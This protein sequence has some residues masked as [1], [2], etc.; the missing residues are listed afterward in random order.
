LCRD[1]RAR[2]ANYGDFRYLYVRSALDAAYNVNGRWIGNVVG[3]DNILC[4]NRSINA[5]NHSDIGNFEGTCN[6]FDQ[7]SYWCAY[8]R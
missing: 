7:R 8:D 4:G 1:L 5:D 3:D 6:R 2:V